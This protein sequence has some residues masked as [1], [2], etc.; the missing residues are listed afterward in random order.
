MAKKTAVKEEVKLE[1]SRSGFTLI[2]NV[3]LTDNTFQPES[4]SK[5]GFI[6]RR[7]NLGVEVGEGKVSYAEMFGGFHRDKPRDIIAFQKASEGEDKGGRL[8]V[9]WED[10]LSLDEATFAT[11]ADFSLLTV[12]LEKDS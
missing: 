7:L 10:R 11:I 5:G 3:K 6:S 4:T 1:P 8:E 9:A 2:G 12:A